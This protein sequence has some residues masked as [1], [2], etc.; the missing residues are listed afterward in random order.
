[1]GKTAQQ[2]VSLR[3]GDNALI[4]APQEIA[5]LNGVFGTLG[6]LQA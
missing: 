5:G 4:D 6:C 3:L 2:R 1:M